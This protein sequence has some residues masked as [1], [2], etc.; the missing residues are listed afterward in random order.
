MEDEQVAVDVA[1]HTYFH[2]LNSHES[3]AI[4]T[5]DCIVDSVERLSCR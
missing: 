4:A 2:R 3:V 1:Q 5:I